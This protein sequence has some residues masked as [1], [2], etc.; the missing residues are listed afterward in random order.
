MVLESSVATPERS[1]EAL[2]WAEPWN[3]DGRVT[4]V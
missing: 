4:K 1:R 2:R 3:G